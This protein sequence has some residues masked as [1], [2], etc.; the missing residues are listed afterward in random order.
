MEPRITNLP[1][2]RVRA[3]VANAIV[4]AESAT[5]A[6]VE[7]SKIDSHVSRIAVSR[8]DRNAVIDINSLLDQNGTP[9]VEHNLRKALRGF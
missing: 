5:H 4:F 9:L 7:F 2:G 8:G 6:A 3:E 1:S